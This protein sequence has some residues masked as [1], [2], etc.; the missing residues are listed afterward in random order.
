[1]VQEA[2]LREYFERAGTLARG[3]GFLARFLIAWPQSTQGTRFFTEPPESWP[4]LARFNTRLRSLLDQPVELDDEGRL[5]PR[6]L[7][8]SIEAK[9]LWVK[10]HDAIEAELLPSGEL[11][12]VRDVAAKVADNA[13]RIASLLHQFE[14][15]LEEPIGAELMESAT[16]LAAWHLNESRRFFGELA[17]PPEIL[18]ASQLERW[19]V[20]YCHKH[21]TTKV[22]RRIVQQYVTPSSLRRSQTLETAIETLADHGRAREWAEDRQKLIE[23]RPEVLA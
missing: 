4:K 16:R 21:G 8:L 20:A 3:T 14:R 19:L 9:A 1:M 18:A 11:Y 2:T 23:L 22:N 15:S 13:A 12:D 17:M 6:V 7:G 10:F 5:S